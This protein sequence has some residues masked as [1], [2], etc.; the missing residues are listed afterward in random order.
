MGMPAAAVLAS[1]MIH[2]F[3]PRFLSMTGIAAAVAG[4][5]R[6]GDVMVADPAWDWG[7]GKWSIDNATGRSMFHPAPHQI[8]L[9]PSTR[10][11]FE[12][13]VDDTATLRGIRD[14]WPA[15]KPDHEFQVPA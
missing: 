4:E 7:S 8:P 14:A 3:R 6:F 12:L 9:S 13:L 15:D 11:M 5:A 10:R 2:H 1:K